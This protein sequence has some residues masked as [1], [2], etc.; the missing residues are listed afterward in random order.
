MIHVEALVNV[1]INSRNDDARM[2]IRAFRAYTVIKTLKSD[3]WKSRKVAGI[4]R[5]SGKAVTLVS[6]AAEREKSARDTRESRRARGVSKFISYRKTSL[7]AT[8]VEEL[9]RIVVTVDLSRVTALRLT[10]VI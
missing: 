7:D 3:T 1:W 4:W 2:F 8:A 9:A 10:R 5:R 6:L